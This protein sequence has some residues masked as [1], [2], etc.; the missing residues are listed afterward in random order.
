MI[1]IITLTG[2]LGSGKTTL[3]GQ[4]LKRPELSNSAVVVNEF[5]EIGL[6]QN[7]VSG[8]DTSLIELK[9][10]CLCCISRSSLGE[11]LISL[12]DHR[13]Q[14]D[15]PPFD[16]II[17]ETSG[18]AD[19]AAISHTITSDR[20]LQN[21][22]VVS[23]TITAIDSFRGAALLHREPLALKQAALADSLV[24]TKTDLSRGVSPDLD[25]LLKQ[26]NGLA[27]RTSAVNGMMSEDDFNTALGL[28]TPRNI[29]WHT[30]N[31]VFEPDA[32]PLHGYP[33]TICL[34]REKPVSALTLAVFMEV[35]SEHFGHEIL[36]SKGIIRLAEYDDRPLAIQGVEQHF[37]PT[38]FLPT[39]PSQDRHSRLV[40]IARDIQK[41]WVY[42]LMDAVELEVEQA[43]RNQ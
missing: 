21:C 31:V 19:P 2:Y 24:L 16:R 25:A 36:R 43:R 20:T 3:L 18:L 12:V 8:N 4:L 9:T 22:L 1:P 29:D 10:G 27:D 41:S 17:I 39:W 23:K 7:F 11:T 14:Q 35:T 6:D 15:R 28:P 30:R 26:V 33:Q 40:F 32:A 42:A 34:S 5:G 13:S 37:D 38:N